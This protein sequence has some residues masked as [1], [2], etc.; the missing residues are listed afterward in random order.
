MALS[1]LIPSRTVLLVSDEALYVYA[2]RAHAVRLVETVPWESDNFESDVA[3]ILSKDCGGKP[4]V[5]LN[6][7]VEQ[8]YRKEKILRAAGGV[9][10]KKG[11][12]RQKLRVAFPSY[13]VRSALKLKEKIAQ[14]GNKGPSDLY[15]F[16]AVP[17][18]KQISR[19]M[20]AVV[21]SLASV[22][23]FALLPVESSD[24]VK[25]LSLK[26]KKPA[27]SGTQW[28]VFIGQHR[29]G[30][31][32]QIVIKNGELALT[33]MSPI[34]ES[35]EKPDVWADE[36][37]QEFNATMSYL[38][39]FGYQ[40]DD[41]LQVIAISS[42]AG[43]QALESMMDPAH[44]FTAMT[45]TE[46]ASVLGIS[47][48]QQDDYRFADPLHAAWVGRKNALLLPMESR[49]LDDITKPRRMA[50]A[51]SVLM[52]CGVAF[53]G[54]Q[55][56]DKGAT[57]S[58]LNTDIEDNTAKLAQLE[59]EYQ[60]EMEHNKKLGFDVRLVQSSIAVNDALEKNN[61]KPL[62]IYNAVGMALGR[63]MRVDGIEI[64]NTTLVKDNIIGAA[65]GIAQGQPVP[66][67]AYEAK[68]QM[69]YPST[70][71]AQQG[72]QEVDALR[73][74]LQ[75]LMTTSKVEITKRLKDYEYVK[76]IVVETGDKGNQNNGQD[77]I[78]EIVIKGPPT[79]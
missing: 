56:V 28:V 39:R 31:L 19:T 16:A 15:I 70:V 64:K 34:V 13:P 68:M 18:S 3:R 71:D 77:L 55:L 66:P 17:D 33:R 20:D 23:G 67:P 7:M 4:A 29:H 59:V 76:E 65:I 61:L 12:I 63:D 52:L 22:A 78:A 74:R 72:N 57:M 21:Q 58:T 75:N 6:D 37:F 27:K 62:E 10:D 41:G 25:A 35:E 2:C 42:A 49:R 73:T 36:V 8:H 47:L 51:A 1:F 79:Q 9:L 40:Q 60:Q 32:R 14:A 24:M 53:L 69:T 44:S 54:Y 48:G 45:V 5:I 38:G 43:G 26:L 46:A 11:M 30:G 50:T